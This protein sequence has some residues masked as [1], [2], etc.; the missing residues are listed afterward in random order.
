[1]ARRRAADLDSKQGLAR[2]I[3]ITAQSAFSL[4][5]VLN[6]TP[7][8]TEVRHERGKIRLAGET[9]LRSLSF[10]RS[11]YFYKGVGAQAGYP[12]P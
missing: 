9:T 6:I 5:N 8:L 7:G 2:R 11:A 10:P 12:Q 1:M 4:L 3:G